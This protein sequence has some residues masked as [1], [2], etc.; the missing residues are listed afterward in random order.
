MKKYFKPLAL[1]IFSVFVMKNISCSN[2]NNV[3]HKQDK[4]IKEITKYS[5]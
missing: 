2:G 5:F 1:N 4:I 3:I